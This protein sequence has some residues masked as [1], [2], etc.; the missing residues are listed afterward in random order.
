MVS[1][2][3]RA[4]ILIRLARIQQTRARNIIPIFNNTSLDGQT[5]KL[6]VLNPVTAEQAEDYQVIVT[7]N[8]GAM[9]SSV[10]ALSVDAP[11]NATLLSQPYGDTVSVG[12]YFD[13]TVGTG[14]TPPLLELFPTR[15]LF[16]SM[17]RSNF[18][19]MAHGWI[20]RFCTGLSVCLKQTLS[21]QKKLRHHLCVARRLKT[22]QRFTNWSKSEVANC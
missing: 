21:A 11:F 3:I 9:T 16:S 14:E 12:G 2:S 20:L 17:A 6:L 4:E 7:N 19:W 1:G 8:F 22:K 5:N 15:V 13:F 18:I 10:A